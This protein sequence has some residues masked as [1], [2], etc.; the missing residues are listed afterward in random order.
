M[1]A[2]A[3]RKVLYS[4]GFGAGWSTW[5]DDRLADAMLFDRDLIAAVES[6]ST[7]LGAAD[8]PTTPLGAFAVRIA[9]LFGADEHVCLLGARDLRVAEVCGPFRVDEHDG[10]ESIMLRDA[11]RWH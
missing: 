1:S 2:D 11:M 5:N 10:S 7:P 8:D 6:R 3:P 9:K 4:P